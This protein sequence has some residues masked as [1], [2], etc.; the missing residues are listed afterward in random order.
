MELLRHPESSFS[1][2]SGHWGHISVVVKDIFIFKIN[3]PLTQLDIKGKKL[4][5]QGNHDTFS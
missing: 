3:T 1:L 4:K 2:G 5:P